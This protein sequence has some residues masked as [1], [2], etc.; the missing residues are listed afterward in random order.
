METDDPVVAEY[1]V[2]AAQTLGRVL[3]LF[4]YPLR[5][6]ARPYEASITNLSVTAGVG[7]DAGGAAPSPT[8][9][10]FMDVTLDTSSSDSFVKSTDDTD[11]VDGGS[12]HM[13]RYALDSAPCQLQS[14]Y[15]A[16]LFDGD[17]VHLTN[18]Q[19]VQQ[20]TPRV[21]HADDDAAFLSTL[22]SDE[23]TSSAMQTHLTKQLSK[24]RSV[25]LGEDQRTSQ[26]IDFY[27]AASVEAGLVRRRLAAATHTAATK[28]HT[29]GVDAQGR[30]FPLDAANVADDAFR[31]QRATLLRYAHLTNSV[32]SQI[33]SLLQSA[34]IVTVPMLLAT[35]HAQDGRPVP[36]G[37]I[38]GVLK[39]IAVLV[40]GVW[41]ICYDQS[42][43]GPQAFV[44]E[45]VLQC[46][47]HAEQPSLLMAGASAVAA[48]N[49]FLQRSVRN[50]VSSLAE[51]RDR[52]WHLKLAST[53]GA[54]WMAENASNDVAEQRMQ[55]TK[56]SAEIQNNMKQ[57]AEG[58]TLPNR[59]LKLVQVTS[60][61]QT[62]QRQTASGISAKPVAPGKKEQQSADAATFIRLTLKA[63]G[64]VV[65]RELMKQRIR[66]ML[67]TPGCII[68]GCPAD[69]IQPAMQ[70]QLMSFTSST[71]ILKSVEPA[72]DAIRTA[73]I[74]AIQTTETFTAKDVVGVAEKTLAQAGGASAI[75]QS[76]ASAVIG[77]LAEYNQ[78]ERLWHVKTGRVAWE[79]HP[80]PPGT[81]R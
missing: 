69:V 36:T 48:N 70:D 50:V 64:G 16:A 15:A 19:S 6:A 79:K 2:F 20:F 5:T 26:P 47:A 67:R 29:A 18:I 72:T 1:P 38:V 76:V 63:V 80:A 24:L 7:S 78:G 59:M 74:G 68:H 62:P 55:W 31:V 25:V 37:T 49:V 35:V 60:M 44:R 34:R 30:F 61:T 65:N 41:V 28:P 54:Q 13:Y 17:G 57:I 11:L 10:F 58:K 42:F 33:K 12:G 45:H 22:T 32:E 21:P 39:K 40:H 43:R 27:A 3:H 4:Q 23:N 77:E 46:F 73:I 81:M 66:E 51:L 53:S 14:S 75:P 52:T 56:R 9:R 71:W 8:S